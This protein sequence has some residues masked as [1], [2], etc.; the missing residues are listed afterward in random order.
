MQIR[1][2]NETDLAW[3]VDVLQKHWGSPTIVTRGKSYD[4][5]T[6]PALLA[7]VNGERAGLLTYHTEGTE[8]EIVSLNSLVE[9]KGI[10]LA[11]LDQLK[12]IARDAH[13]LRVWLIITN[14][15]LHALSF[16]QKRGFTLAALYPN[17]L[18]QTRK[19]KPQLPLIGKDGIPLRDEI[20]LEFRIK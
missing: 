10:G 5:R 14:D 4:A 16:Y 9:G 20:E 15:N 18:E 11:L 2:A 17:A 8:C 1:D 12:A 6:L 7:L 13:C 19:I 3:I